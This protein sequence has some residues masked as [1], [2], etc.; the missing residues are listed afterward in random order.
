MARDTRTRIIEAALEL[1]SERSYHEVSVE[2]IARKAGVSKGGLFHHFPSKYELAKAVFFH[3][4]TQWE[5]EL[6]E[7]MEKADGPEERLRVLVGAMFDF[8]SQNQKLYRFFLEFYEESLKRGE[9]E[10]EWREMAERYLEMI[11][12]L[13]RDAGVENPRVRAFL[14]VSLIDGFA[15][16]YLFLD[17]DVSVEEAKRETLRMVLCR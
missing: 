6:G 5:R 15:F 17:G 8:V 10:E 16:D 3:Y 11:E 4:L 7:V 12:G 13:L 14:L 2:E 9:W 1:F